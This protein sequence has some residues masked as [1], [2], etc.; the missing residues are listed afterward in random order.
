MINA[1][2]WVRRLVDSVAEATT[3]INSDVELG[4]H[5]FQNQSGTVN[6]WEITVFGEPVRMGGRL[7]SYSMDPVFSIDALAV[8]TV[9]DTLISCRW[10][11]GQIDSEDDLGTHLSIEGIQNG[12]AVWLR[13][14]G[15]KPKAIHSGP[16]TSSQVRQ[17]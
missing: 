10:Q 12:E 8:A 7:A 1:P 11:T 5:V 15:Q 2:E 13:I 14:V 16:S 17:K 4:C 9:F 6:E 3:S